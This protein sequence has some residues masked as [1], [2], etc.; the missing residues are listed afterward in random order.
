MK[1]E[2]KNRAEARVPSSSM[3]D[4]AFLLLV[5]FM[6]TT[7]LKLEEGMPISIPKAEAAQDVPRDKVMRIWLSGAGEIMMNDMLITVADVEP[8]VVKRLMENPG[9]I[10]AF[11]TDSGCPYGVLSDVMDQLKRANAVRV[12]FTAKRE[13]KGS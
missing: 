7:V 5:F 9:L 8:M 4:I 2:R 6:V 1:I 3:A 10:V 13:L 12:S 11:N